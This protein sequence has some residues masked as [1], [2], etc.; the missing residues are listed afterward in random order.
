M[1][2]S[3]RACVENYLLDANLIHDYWVEKYTEKQENPNLKWG[4]GD[5]PDISVIE[6]W[7]ESSAK[8]LQDYQAVRWALAD[9]LQMND[10]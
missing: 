7:I 6:E 2:L 9:L 8:D 4:H 1:F 3:Y 5:A 10:A